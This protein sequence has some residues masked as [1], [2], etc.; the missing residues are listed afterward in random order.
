MS[1]FQTQKQ[2]K[3]QC[4][5]VAVWFNALRLKKNGIGISNPEKYYVIE[6]HLIDYKV[7]FNIYTGWGT[8][9]NLPLEK[10]MNWWEEEVKR[11][12]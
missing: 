6:S 8:K 5:L 4:L 9:Q 7:F 3:H 12:F 10:I 11:T 2:T 1:I